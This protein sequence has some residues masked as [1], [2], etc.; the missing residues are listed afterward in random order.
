MKRLITAIVFLLTASFALA[1][2]SDKVAKVTIGSIQHGQPLTIQ[3]DLMQSN[4]LDQVEIAYRQFGERN[5][6]HTEMTLTNNTASFSL[7]AEALHPPFI[8]YYF[9]LHIRGQVDPE[10]YPLE[11]AEQQPFRIDLKPASVISSEF[12][13]LSPEQD[14]HVYPE[15]FL[16]SFTLYYPDSLI[17]LNS[18]QIFLDEN[19]LS[20]YAL[21]AED[22]FVLKPENANISFKG[23]QHTIRVAIKDTLGNPVKSFSWYFTVIG[24]GV[25]R[26]TGRSSSPWTYSS[27]FQLETRQENI[28]DKVTPYNRGTISANGAYDVYR[29]KGN[30]YLTNE[31]KDYRQP[32]NRFF[33][34][35]ESPWLKIGY[36]DSYPIFPDFFL[37]GKRVRGLTGSI[38]VD[39]LNLDFA[40]GSITRQIEGKLCRTFLFDS[41]NSVKQDTTRQDKTDIF[42]PYQDSLWAEYKYGT[43]EREL[44]II[45]PSFGKREGTHLG[46]TYLKS[47]DDISSIR[48]G[49]KPEENVVLGSDF[50][51]S[52][53]NR[54]FEFWGQA[55]LSAS[56][57]DFSKGKI[58]DSEIDSMFA[59]E[60][61]K[62][63]DNIRKLRD[64]ISPV[65][66]VNQHLIPLPSKNTPTSTLSY[67]AGT[68][69]NYFNNTFKFSYLRRGESYESFGQ[70]FLRTDVQ[71]YNV[72]DRLRLFDNQIFVLAGHER[73]VDNTVKTKIATTVSATT[74]VG[75]SYYPRINAPS[76][77]I[78]YLLNSN[79]NG[80]QDKFYGTDDKT[81]RIIFQIGKDYNFINLRHN[82]SMGVS[83]SNKDDYTERNF[84]TKNTNFTFSNFSTFKIPLQTMFSLSYNSNRFLSGNNETT[85]LTYTTLSLN[86]NYRMMEDKLRFFGGFNPTFGEISR[87]Q[88]TL[89][90]QYYFYKNLSAQ[91]QMN[92][93]FNQ[94]MYNYSQTSIDIVWNL[95]LRAEI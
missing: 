68:S 1:Q 74:N 60:D 29:V 2:V 14:E 22:L 83:T 77:T 32:Q 17:D 18:I 11:N 37:S 3:I 57:K 70:P 13:I 16:I 66:T 27:S 39:I 7:P 42:A 64:I 45:R 69:L 26:T 80:R 94:K 46:F 85:K 23:G 43:Y 21:R 92:I 10:T 88:T 50:M 48:Y 15:D 93:Y 25:N 35:L 65:I 5:F 38:S 62:F 20:A 49:I 28:S 41:I 86:A 9:I 87:I 36:G 52:F 31:E 78:A 89:S 4:L 44:F 54:N 82:A 91:T 67:D 72:S 47:K 81:N 71:G 79:Q 73:L 63:R 59:N 12:T 8:E 84:D 51:V 19:D 53:D 55:A 76:V 61:N 58:S 24:D 33:I 56:N 30:L 40:K 90:A 6:K 95:I 75:I 34:G